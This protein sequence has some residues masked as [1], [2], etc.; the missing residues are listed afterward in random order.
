MNSTCDLKDF[1]ATSKL[2]ACQAIHDVVPANPSIFFAHFVLQ[3][4]IVHFLGSIMFD[5][6]IRP[7]FFSDS[8]HHVI[9]MINKKQWLVEEASFIQL[10][11]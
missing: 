7:G 8:E 3:L 11:R 4:C 5:G 2:V 6:T 10:T 1:Q 9:F